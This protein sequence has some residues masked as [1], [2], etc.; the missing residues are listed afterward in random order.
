VAAVLAGRGSVAGEVGADDIRAA[1]VRETEA[2]DLER[3][4]DAPLLGL[5]VLRV[6]VIAALDLV[7]EQREVAVQRLRVELLFVERPAELVERGLVVL[8]TAAAVD[9]GR[10]R[11]L[12]LTEF[13]LDEQPLRAPE[14]HFVREPRARILGDEL[15][16]DLHGLFGLPEL[17]VGARLLVE[18]LVTELVLRIL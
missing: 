4:L 2:D 15:L 13:P 12:R 18:D 5:G 1:D 3:V 17:F 14:L 9:Y 7:V 8:R 16:H 6:E 10:V 11:A